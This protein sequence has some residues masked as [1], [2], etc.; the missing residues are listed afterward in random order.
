MMATQLFKVKNHPMSLQLGLRYWAETTDT[1]PEGWG[2][3][4]TYTLVLPK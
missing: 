2:L 4:I 1:S 3:R